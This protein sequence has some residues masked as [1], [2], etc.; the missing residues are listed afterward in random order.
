MME[1]I[2]NAGTNDTLVLALFIVFIVS[3]ILLQTMINFIML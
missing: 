2:V 1:Q 3:M